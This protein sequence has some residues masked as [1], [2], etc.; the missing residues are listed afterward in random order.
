MKFEVIIADPPWSFDDGLKRMR[1]KTKRGAGSNYDVMHSSM[2]ANIDVQS[3]ASPDCI[4][5]MWVPSTLLKDG[6]N[7]VESWGFTL[8]QTF[9]WVKLKKD[10]AKERDPNNKTRVGMG[11]LF[12]QSHEIALVCTRGKPHKNLS[13]R[14]Q[15]SVAFDLNEGHSVKPYTLHERLEEMF[16]DSNKLEMFARR[17][18]IGW[19]CVGNE[20]TGNDINIDVAA[21]AAKTEEKSD[22]KVEE[23]QVG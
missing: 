23:L 11:R 2:I 9:V 10:H 22:G 5:V 14:S 3:I 19:T 20:L 4:L 16:P 6:I 15:R 12:R 8:K 7:V 18:R 13:S 17:N 1:Q 21:L